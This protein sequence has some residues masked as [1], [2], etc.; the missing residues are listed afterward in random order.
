MLMKKRSV[1]DEIKFLLEREKDERR[2]A[3][4]ASSV[5]ARHAHWRMAEQYA[6]QAHSLSES[7]PG[8]AL[9]SGLWPETA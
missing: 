6:D 7:I 3:A 5:C 2:L 8:P 9:R 1:E 4:Q